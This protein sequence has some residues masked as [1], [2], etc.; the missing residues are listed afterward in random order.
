MVVHVFRSAHEDREERGRGFISSRER[1][2]LGEKDNRMTAYQVIQ[3]QIQGNIQGGSC[4]LF[5]L[6]W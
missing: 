1:V 3:V 2:R 6:I 5:L 4:A